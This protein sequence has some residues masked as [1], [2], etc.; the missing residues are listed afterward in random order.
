[1]FNKQ[2]SRSRKWFCEMMMFEQDDAWTGWCSNRMASRARMLEGSWGPRSGVFLNF[3]SEDSFWIFTLVIV[4]NV[5][6]SDCSKVCSYLPVFAHMRL[7]S[8]PGSGKCSHDVPHSHIFGNLCGSSTSRSHQAPGRSHLAVS[9]AFQESAAFISLS[10]ILRRNSLRLWTILANEL[11][12]Q[13][14]KRAEQCFELNKLNKL[15][16]CTLWHSRSGTKL[17]QLM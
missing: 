14:K 13:A 17:N 4:P 8:Q 10:Q 2:C 7:V 9:R 15:L 6:P 1:M 3:R 12:G 11:L 16:V 5:R